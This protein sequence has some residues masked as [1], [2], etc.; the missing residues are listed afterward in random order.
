MEAVE[1]PK[2]WPPMPE[3]IPITSV[4]LPIVTT[5]QPIPF[6]PR[7]IPVVGIPTFPQLPL[8]SMPAHPVIPFHSVVQHFNPPCIPPAFS[9][10]SSMVSP[11]FFYRDVAL[12]NPIPRRHQVFL[13]STNYK[14]NS[15][16]RK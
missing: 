1:I 3:P 12:V 11:K 2:A 16:F 5:T 6:M 7:P 9:M 10:P 4:S 13:Q 15:P 8:C 14:P